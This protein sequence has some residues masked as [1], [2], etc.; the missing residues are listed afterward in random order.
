[1][2]VSARKKIIQLKDLIVKQFGTEIKNRPDCEKLA[3]DIQKRTNHQIS[4]NTLRRFFNLAGKKNS[5]LPS[6]STLD[7]LANYTGYKFFS[8]I[9]MGAEIQNIQQ[10]EIYDI[11]IHF[12]H[13][14]K[15]DILEVFD[16]LEKI[17]THPNLHL[18][19]YQIVNL[20]FQLNDRDFLLNLFTFS[21]I[22]KNQTYLYTHIYYTMISIGLY[23]RKSKNKY[24]LW[25]H[26]SNQTAAQSFYF[27][28]FVDMD[29][30]LT[31]HYLALEQYNQ[32]KKTPEANLFVGSLLCFKHFMT[33]N[34][35]EMSE[36]MEELQSI[37]ISISIHPIPVA[38]FLTCK[39][40]YETS[41]NS[42]PNYQ[43]I[44]EI[45]EMV[46]RIRHHG[47]EGKFTSF[48][49]I[50]L[51]EGLVLSQQFKLGQKLIL[52]LEKYGKEDYTYYNMG[53][54]ERYKMYKA[55]ILLANDNYSGAKFL[56]ESI[57]HKKFH[58]FSQQYETI[59]YLVLSYK[60]SQDNVQLRQAKQIARKLKYSKLVD[61]LLS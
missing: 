32:Y 54:W 48:F 28:L 7:I 5:I 37:E 52:S 51:L 10:E 13:K 29:Y 6:Y 20:S 55:Y 42:T 30:L 47:L 24:E 39:L 27:E 15:I 34:I 49:H 40:F 23:V 17:K 35:A 45:N 25:S 3:I 36:L 4:Y 31:D 59:F 44:Q 56:K 57:N 19:F 58:L 60:I 46:D 9:G 53:D 33:G 14:Q 41:I 38:R 50:W 18:F 61:L 8:Q 43:T 1:M 26:W 21:S 22:F 12:Q 2:E 11:I 16:A